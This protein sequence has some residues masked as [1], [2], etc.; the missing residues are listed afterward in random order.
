M[1]EEKSEI[2][3]RAYD[4]ALR[5][6]RMASVLPRNSINS[7][8]VRQVV[9]S[10]TS[11]GANIE[12]TLGAHTKSDFTYGMNIAKKEA[13]ETRYWLRIIADVDQSVKSRMASL[14]QESEE[15][16]NI[17]TKIVK[18]SKKNL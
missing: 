8:L 15:I 16:I 17:L 1:A 6:I 11:I 18:T 3:K 2:A 4:F 12:E 14:L 7:V 10:A 9:R 13:R 5:V